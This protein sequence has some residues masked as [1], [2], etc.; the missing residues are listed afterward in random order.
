MAFAD[1]RSEE[2]EEWMAHEELSAKAGTKGRDCSRSSSSSQS[3]KV[4][5]TTYCT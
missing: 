1:Q 5:D 2:R 4:T 3:A